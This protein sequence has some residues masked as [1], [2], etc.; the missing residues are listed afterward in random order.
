LQRSEAF[1]FAEIDIEQQEMLAELFEKHDFDCVINL[2]A[3]AGVRYSMENPTVYMQTNAQGTLNL[4]EL[5]REHG[6]N[7]IVQASTSSLYAGQPMPFTEDMPVN[8]PISP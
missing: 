8:E 7:K 1:E 6:I 2:A 4:L 3:R 5:M